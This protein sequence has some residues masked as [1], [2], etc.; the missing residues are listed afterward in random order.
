M[1]LYHDPHRNL[2]VY[3]TD[4]P[5]RI[6]TNVEEARQ[7][8]GHHVA[9]PV[10]LYNLQLLRWLDLPVVPVMASYG[11]PHAP[12]ITPLEHQKLGAN[13]MV[14][15]PRC[16]NLSDMG[17]MKTLT[18]LWAADYI[19]DQYPKG[20]CRGLIVAPLSILQRVWGDAIFKHF[21][22]KR[23][24]QII[25]GSA[26]ARSEKLGKSADFYI[27]NFD[28]L[29][30]GAKT[31]RKFELDGLS[32]AIRD[33]GD[34]RIAIVDEC[35]AYADSTTK[36]HRIAR[37]LLGQRDYLWML[38]GSPTPNGPLD[39]YGQ[40]K[41]LNNAFGESYGGYQ[42]RTM[43]KVTQFKWVPRQGANKA[44]RELLTPAIRFDIKD[45]WNGPAMTVQQRQVDLTADQRKAMNEL[46]RQCQVMVKSG[47]IGIANEAAARTKYIQISGG[48]IYD[49]EH[50]YHVIDSAPR[51]AECEEIIRQTTRK[52]LC[53]VPLTSVLL[54]L[55]K[56]LSKK[57]SCGVLNGDVSPK[58]RAETIRRFASEEHPRIMLADPQTTAHG[59]NEFV[60]ADT[61]I[62]YLP[63]DKTELYLQGNKRAHRPGQKYPVSIVQLVS[64]E[65]EREIFRR[66]ESNEGLQGVLLDM[67]KENRI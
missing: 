37:L 49:N 3:R 27:I 22:G 61:V 28:G 36:R 62:W 54:V 5:G 60:V 35:R 44:A 16:F 39:A 56:H 43:M 19:M 1:N 31:K 26:G 14:L 64:N 63:T 38:T 8:N 51:L 58:D 46:K 42:N 65:L 18:T 17:T 59:I 45:V 11:W 10:S 23:T 15:H 53:F 34:I 48:A 30:V 67:V 50:K 66:L 33:R 24:Y 6:L 4:D 32:A 21:L 29:G 13:F 57:Y 41:L 7:V 55:C 12:G 9:V 52:V 25:H 20:E 40:A 47:P 2:L